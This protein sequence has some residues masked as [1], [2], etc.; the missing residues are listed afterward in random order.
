M[1]NEQDQ[2]NLH[3]HIGI[4]IIM[5]KITLHLHAAFINTQ[6]AVRVETFT[7]YNNLTFHII[8]HTIFRN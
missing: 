1:A 6:I 8:M 3:I 7:I 2:I 5:I 4:I